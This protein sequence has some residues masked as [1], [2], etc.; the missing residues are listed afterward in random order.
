M[1][2]SGRHRQRVWTL[3]PWRLVRLQTQGA[4]LWKGRFPHRPLQPLRRQVEPSPRNTRRNRRNWGQVAASFSSAGPLGGE[5][6]GPGPAGLCHRPRPLPSAG[7]FVLS[8]ASSA[9]K[10]CL[11]DVARLASRWLSCPGRRLQTLFLRRTSECVPVCPSSSVMVSGLT[12]TS[13]IHFG[14]MFV[15]GVQKVV[16]EGVSVQNIYRIHTNQH[17]EKNNLKSSPIRTWAEDPD[18]PFSER[19][20]SRRTNEKMLNT[21]ALREMPAQAAGSCPLT[22]PDW[23]SPGRQ[24]QR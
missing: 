9:V 7:P 6:T 1:T 24:E 10:S 5:G 22:P 2:L 16:R 14:C 19:T 20:C 15:F 13:V 11:L 17:Q 18:R 23:L 21:V 3:Q 8:T 4:G 12:F